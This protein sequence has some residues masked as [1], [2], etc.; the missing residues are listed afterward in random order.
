MW[1]F[2]FLLILFIILIVIILLPRNNLEYPIS[3]GSSSEETENN[4]SVKFTQPSLYPPNNA[5][6]LYTFPIQKIE[7]SGETGSQITYYYPEPP[8]Y[9]LSNMEGSL[10]SV[11]CLDFDQIYASSFIHTCES[12]KS[13]KNTNNFSSQNINYFSGSGIIPNNAQTTQ[14][15]I[16]VNG[17]LLNVGESEVFYDSCDTIPKCSGTLGVIAVNYNVGIDLPLLCSKRIPTS[18]GFFSKALPCNPSDDQQLFRINR[19]DVK[20]QSNTSGLFANFYLRSIGQYLNVSSNTGTVYF[21]NSYYNGAGKPP[22][23]CN[24]TDQTLY[25]PL[26]TYDD[27]PGYNW[28]LCPSLQYNTPGATGFTKPGTIVIGD[29]PI[30]IPDAACAYIPYGYTGFIAVGPN[31]TVPDCK[32]NRIPKVT[33]TPQQIIN[34]KGIDISGYSDNIN[35][36]NFFSYLIKNGAQSLYCPTDNF[37]SSPYNLILQPI[38]TDIN[39]CKNLPF[40]SQILPLQTYNYVNNKQSCTSLNKGSD[41]IQ[42]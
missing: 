29:G 42:N 31:I 7:S 41:C 19:V 25:G 15:C 2:I 18:T 1:I 30:T 6:L 10:T 34:I 13:V 38:A 26:L 21:E 17:S 36:E 40:I 9:N 11:N 32:D 8:N 23:T 39:Q 22:Y 4:I 14:K 12:T 20:K 28:F 35:L 24:A 5:C 27:D 33:I 16:G 37:L 3:P